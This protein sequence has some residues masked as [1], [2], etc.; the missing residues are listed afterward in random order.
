M[1]A[2]PNDGRQVSPRP[3]G[4]TLFPLQQREWARVKRIVLA[5]S[6]TIVFL[7]SLLELRPLIAALVAAGLMTLVNIAV[8]ATLRRWARAGKLHPP[9][10]RQH[11]PAGQD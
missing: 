5:S 10:D 6:F 4:R 3:A 8:E 11:S 2:D 9:D 7:V 1:N